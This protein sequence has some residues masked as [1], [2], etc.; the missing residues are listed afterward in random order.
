MG[1]QSRLGWITKAGFLSCNQDDSGEPHHYTVED[2]PDVA[3]PLRQLKEESYE[4]TCALVRRVL[5]PSYADMV[6]AI[7]IDGMKIVE[8]AALIS[9]KPDNVSHRLRRAEKAEDFLKNVLFDPLPWQQD[10]G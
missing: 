8:Y 5:K 1:M 7:H 6:I 2:F 3:G 10:G 4:E 9:D